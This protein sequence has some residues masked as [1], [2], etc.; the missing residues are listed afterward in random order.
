MAVFVICRLSNAPAVRAALEREFPS[1]Y[2]D[3][4][5]NAWLLAANRAT[6]KSVSDRLGISDG[7]SGSGLVVSVRNYFGRAPDAV[8]DWLEENLRG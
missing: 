5:Y 2:F 1:D 6:A 4:G 3:L 8:W 7:A